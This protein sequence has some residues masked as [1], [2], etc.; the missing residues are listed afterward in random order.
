MAEQVNHPKHYRRGKIETW[1]F[2]VDQDFPYLIGNA[3][4]YL[5]RY[6]YKQKPVEDL[7]KAVAYINKQ[8][9]VLNAS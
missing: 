4:K 6:R 5:A 2:I 8:I 3:V 1:D 9:E 7:K